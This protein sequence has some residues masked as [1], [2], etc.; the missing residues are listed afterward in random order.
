MD[1]RARARR[2]HLRRSER[3]VRLRE[4]AQAHVT[5]ENRHV[6]L[7]DLSPLTDFVVNIIKVLVDVELWL[8]RLVVEQRDV[9]L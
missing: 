3:P 1:D 5:A 2:T 4:L 7:A 6:A 9:E 8:V